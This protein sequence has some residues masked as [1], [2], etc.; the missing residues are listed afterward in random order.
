MQGIGTFDNNLVDGLIENNVV[1]LQNWNGI[2]AYGGV[3]T[4][5][6]NNTVVDPYRYGNDN[7]D[8]PCISIEEAQNGTNSRNCVV[9]NNIVETVW[10]T[11]S[12]TPTIDH[13]LTGEFDTSKVFVDFANLN[14]RLKAGSPAIDAGSSALAPS[15]DIDGNSRP[16]GAA[17]DIG[18]YEYGATTP[19]PPPPPPVTYTISASASPAAGGTVS[20][21]STHEEGTTV[22]LKATANS[23][24]DFV[25]WTEGA[26]VVSTSASY[27]FTAAANRTLVANFAAIPRPTGHLH[28][29]R[30]GQP[31]RG[32]DCQRSQYP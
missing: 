7:Y 30:F 14:L 6:I 5:I 23:G 32:R 3:G 17:W 10:K 1:M 9:R 2:F 19:P 31:G 12:D 15:V 28:H 24:Y 18:A 27:S 20:G 26:A 29:H 25:N 16:Q 4:K 13:N 21:A 8:H 11:G 22:T